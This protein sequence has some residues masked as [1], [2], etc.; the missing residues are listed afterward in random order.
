MKRISAIAS[1]VW[2][3]MIRRKDL[4]VLLILLVSLLFVLMTVNVFDLGNVVRFVADVGLL[5]AWLFSIVLTIGLSARQLP[6]EEAKGTIYPLLAKPITRWE[7]IA[8]KWLGAWSAASAATLLFH[9]LILVV[10]VLRGGT[11]DGV[12]AVQ[13]MLLHVCALAIIAAIG[14]A[15]ST[16][17]TGSAA[18]TIAY[19]VTAVCAAVIPE[20]P[21]LLLHQTGSAATA[22]SALYYALP[23]LELFD[24]RQRLVHSWGPAPWN[25]VLSVFVYGCVWTA[26]LLLLAWLG[27]RG[28]RF[29]RGA[30]S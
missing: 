22:L 11:F 29:Q 1:V 21:E 4:Y 28:K 15:V 13:G 23:H 24:L 25:V 12:S 20:V 27:Y 26:I 7:L 8:G 9:A 2:R 6:A 17:M 19:V 10:V 14:M 16:R 30:A 18:A 5:F 3:E